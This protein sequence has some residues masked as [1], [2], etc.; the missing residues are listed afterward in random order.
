MVSISADHPLT[1]CSRLDSNQNT[2][3]NTGDYIVD[4]VVGI[5]VVSG[6][7]VD[8][9]TFDFCAYPTYLYFACIKNL[10]ACF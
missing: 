5:T 9:N 1:P 4:S 6:I 3:I 2:V 10:L 8:A 7:A